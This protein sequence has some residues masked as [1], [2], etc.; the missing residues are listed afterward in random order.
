[1]NNLGFSAEEKQTIWNIVASC[2]HLGE[3][4]VDGSTYDEGG[5]PCTIKN[6]DVRDIIAKL[7]G[8]KDPNEFE[9]ELMFKPKM[10]GIT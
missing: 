8:F 4:E 10:K 7:L 9:E 2:L 6:K 5:K 1:M 3:L